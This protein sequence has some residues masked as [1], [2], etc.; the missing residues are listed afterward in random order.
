[1]HEG[2]IGKSRARALICWPVNQCS[3]EDLVNISWLSFA[4]SFQIP[5]PYS[6][7]SSQQL[8]VKWNKNRK[9]KKNQITHTIIP[10][11]YSFY[12]HMPQLELHNCRRDIHFFLNPWECMSIRGRLKTIGQINLGCFWRLVFITYFVDI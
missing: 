6:S 5:S 12:F 7:S 2:E 4:F 8:K 1:M 11:Q 3:L 9:K 10:I